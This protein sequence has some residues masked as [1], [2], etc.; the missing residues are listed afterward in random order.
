MNLGIK[1]IRPFIGSKDFSISAA[2]YKELGFEETVLFHDMSVFDKESIS[3]YLQNAYVKDWIENT[4]LFIEVSN[5]DEC[6]EWL[7]SLNLSQKYASVKLIPVRREEW[8]AECFLTDPAGI[9]LHFG[10][11]N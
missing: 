3:F 8:G 6:Y 10:Q 4:M 1:S 9:L 2:F 5:V 11:F 7:L